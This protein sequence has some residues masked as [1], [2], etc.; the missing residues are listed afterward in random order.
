MTI[1]LVL[2]AVVSKEKSL[3]MLYSILPICVVGYS[4]LTP[5]L[6]ALLSLRCGADE[7][8]EMLGVGQSMSA[9][10]RILGPVVG[11]TLF[12]LGQEQPELGVALPYWMGAGLMLVGVGMVVALRFEQAKTTVKP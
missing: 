10:A 2:I 1:G 5:S 9:L 8:G 12:K 6:Q 3:G 11:V 7:Q 4:A